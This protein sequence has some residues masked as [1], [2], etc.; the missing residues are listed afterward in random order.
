MNYFI[1]RDGQEYGPYTLG[2]LQRYVASGNILLTDMARSEGMAEPMMV[3]QIIGTIPVPPQPQPVGNVYTG[4]IPSAPAGAYYPD[5]P[6]LH[7]ALVL[8]FSVLSCGMFGAVW[9][10]VEASWMKKVEPLS[11]AMGYYIAAI[12]LL[13][14]LFFSG[15]FMAMAGHPRSPITSLIQLVYAVVAIIARFSLRSSIEEHFNTAEPMGVTLNGVMT[16]FFGEIYFQYHFNEINKRKALG[17]MSGYA[18]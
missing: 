12:G 7:W 17:R 11:K 15:F 2:D 9:S 13:V 4:G 10:L 5:P 1:N 18:A 6:N 3:S 16:F 8:L 14:V